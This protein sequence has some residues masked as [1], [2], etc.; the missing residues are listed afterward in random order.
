MRWLTPEEGAK[1]DT[2]QPGAIA[3][4]LSNSNSQFLDAA[5]AYA[6]EG[7]S[8]FPLMAR[9]KT[10]AIPRGH[11]VGTT[12]PDAIRDWWGRLPD[13]NIGIVCGNG[14]A[15]LDVDVANGGKQA[16]SELLELHGSITTRI[17]S[18]GTHGLHIYL[19][20]D[21]ANPIQ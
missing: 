21:R 19:R 17:I 12:D 7:L 18:T 10:P 13:A 6:A 14:L 2:I 8:V 5:L 9:G 3:P 1:M 4:K 11:T 16:L 20:D 15:V